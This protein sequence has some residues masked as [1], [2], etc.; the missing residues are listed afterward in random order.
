MTVRKRADFDW[1][2][3]YFPITGLLALIIGHCKNFVQ[4]ANT[5]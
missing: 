1:S 3:C 4:Y 5:E 2:L